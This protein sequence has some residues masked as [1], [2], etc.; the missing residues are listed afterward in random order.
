VAAASGGD[1]R[2]VVDSLLT[3]MRDGLPSGS[4]DGGY[5]GPVPGPADCARGHSA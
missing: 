4:S 2:P 3:E 1:L 5:A